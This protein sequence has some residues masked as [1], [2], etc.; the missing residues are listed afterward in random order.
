[1]RRIIIISAINL[2]SGGTLSILNECL[3]Y[4]D[5][6]LSDK[7]KIIALV[8]SKSVLTKTKNIEYIE[9]PKS[10]RS[11][12]YRI[13][14]EYFYFRKLS[15]KFKPYLWLLLHDMTPNV[16]A[17]IKAVYCHNPAPFYKVSLRE[18]KYDIKFALFCWFY[19]WV[20]RINI[21]K[22]NYV[23]VQQEWLRVK[24][25][26]MYGVKNVIVAHPEI[27]HPEITNQISNSE[28]P[29]KDKTTFFYPAFP[30]VFKNFEIICEAARILEKK[31]LDQFEVVLTI[32]GTEN[33]YAKWLYKKYNNLK[34]VKFIGL[35]SRES[36]FEIFKKTDCLI[37]P[38]KLETW[39]LPISEFKK[40][41]KPILVA[42]LPYAYETVG[43]Y[44]KVK[45]FDPNDA[46]QLAA[47]MEQIINGYFVPDEPKFKKIA[48]PYASSWKDLF[49]I[50][51]RKTDND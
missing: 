36:I 45:Y 18:V 16:I 7:Y 46:M 8:H 10:I 47:L 26:E 11:Y 50:L 21:K 1:M 48:Q 23:I 34:S 5:R 41:N 42:D 25:K 20:Y 15:K 29:I 4:L 14:Y 6:M 13:Y 43:C 24:F 40:Y 30:R 28:K 17:D 37:F 51:L 3:H 12:L 44:K 38:S 22:N 33:R 19:K 35:Q 39:G 9:F 32:S 49:D 31:Y 27:A 2:R